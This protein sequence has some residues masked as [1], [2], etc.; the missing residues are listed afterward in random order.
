MQKSQ[1]IL[2]VGASSA[3]NEK[4][5][6]TNFIVYRRQSDTNLKN[7]YAEDADAAEMKDVGDA[8]ELIG[9]RVATTV[10]VVHDGDFGHRRR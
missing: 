3:V 10:L 9:V 8:E 7:E 4:I 2:R 5:R 6:I 1:L